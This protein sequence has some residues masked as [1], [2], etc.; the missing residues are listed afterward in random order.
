MLEVLVGSA[1][2][3]IL[4]FTRVKSKFISDSLRL[5]VESNSLWLEDKVPGS[6][7]VVSYC[8]LKASLY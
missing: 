1:D 7:P 6:L 3:S 2:F 4:G 5:L 8:L